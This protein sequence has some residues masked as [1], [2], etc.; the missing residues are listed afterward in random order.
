MPDVDESELL[1][2]FMLLIEMLD[3]GTGHLS[4]L[5]LGGAG[6]WSSAEDG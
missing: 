4:L 3:I 2:I 1:I 6:H 5:S